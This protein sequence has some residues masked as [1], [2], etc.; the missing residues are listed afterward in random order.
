MVN[1]EIVGDV[2]RGGLCFSATLLVALGSF[3]LTR[4]SDAQSVTWFNL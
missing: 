4:P 3:C 2:V 1:R